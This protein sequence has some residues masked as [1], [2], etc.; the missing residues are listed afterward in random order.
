MKILI[1]EDAHIEQNQNLDRFQYLGKLIVQ[2][3]PDIIISNGDFI[4]FE[5]ISNWNT[6]KKLTLEGLRYSK[7][8]EA[9]NTALTY[10][11]E[12][13]RELQAKQSRF[14]VKQYKPELYFIS[15]NHE[16]RVARYVQ[17]NPQLEGIM[18]IQDSL[19]LFDR[20]WDVIPYKS[21]LEIKGIQFT[22]VPITGN[23]QP[24][25]GTNVISAGLRIVSKSTVW[26]H[27]HY[28]ASGSVKR[29]G[30]SDLIQGLTCGCFFDDE[31]IY[32]K[33]GNNNYFRGVVILDIIREGKFDFR[34]ISL[35]RLYDF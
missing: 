9:G 28:V 8:I 21:Y 16:E 11:E 14:K 12:P 15:G 24:V 31:S 5:S 3:K 34:T 22:H 17:E 4:S 25:S 6:S 19:N 1:F 13:L 32:A 33:G 35:E 20:G 23:G 10:L 30:S 27:H 29:H 7:E 26:G 2:E 18:S